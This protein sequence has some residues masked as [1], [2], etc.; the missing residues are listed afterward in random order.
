VRG[1]T[2]RELEILGLL[3]EGNTFRRGA[4]TL[5]LSEYAMAAHLEDIRFKLEASTRNLAV[6]RAARCGLYVPSALSAHHSAEGTATVP[7]ESAA[8]PAAKPF[9]VRLPAS[10]HR[11]VEASEAHPEHPFTTRDIAELAHVSP[12]TLQQGFRQHMGISPMG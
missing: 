6:L 8:R 10:L 5:G 11:A 2:D 9:A 1:L 3:I 7:R 12:R 4:A